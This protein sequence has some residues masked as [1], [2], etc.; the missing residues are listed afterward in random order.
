MRHSLLQHWQQADGARRNHLYTVWS[1]DYTYTI[2]QEGT[3]PVVS[4][5]GDMFLTHDTTYTTAHQFP[6]AQKARH[7]R[8][9]C[10]TELKK[11]SNLQLLSTDTQTG[12]QIHAGWYSV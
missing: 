11:D 3:V 10:E 9:K 1:R 6:E 4:H 12:T 8:I 2:N 5:V 7:N